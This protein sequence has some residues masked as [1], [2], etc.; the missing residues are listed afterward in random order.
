MVPWNSRLACSASLLWFALHLCPGRSL[1]IQPREVLLI[2]PFKD[3]SHFPGKWDLQQGIPLLLGEFLRKDERHLI[4][5]AD[6][7]SAFLSEGEGLTSLS[8]DQVLRIGREVNTDLVVTGDIRNFSIKRFNMGNP[9]IGGYT[10]YVVLVEV[11]AHL[12][13]T[14][15]AVRIGEA[16]GMAELKGR[17]LG[18]T[19][20]G[21]PTQ[22]DAALF[23]LDEI[24]FGS[25]SFRAT[26][27]GEAALQALQQ[28]AEEIEALV[29]APAILQQKDPKVLS[30]ERDEVYLNVGVADKIEIGHKFA[31]CSQGGAQRIGLVQI[32]AVYAQHLSKAQVLEGQGA[33]QEGDVLCAE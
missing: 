18:L 20:L 26:L 13:R 6:T 15:S 24:S 5:S 25:D 4:L 11:E 10:S 3:H 21:K 32:V 17:D 29:C 23:G 16:R 2:A 14:L 31:V 7:I 28:L 27:I 1:A 22:K 8:D 30:L 9:L 12:L 19:L 33:V